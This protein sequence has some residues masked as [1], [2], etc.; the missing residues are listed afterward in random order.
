[1]RGGSRVRETL[2]RPRQCP[3]CGQE[4]AT[5]VMFRVGVFFFF[6][7]FFFFSGNHVKTQACG[8]CASQSCDFPVETP[9][10]LKTMPS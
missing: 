10:R 8:P 2:D 6:F 5:E 3:C 9:T 4:G 7:F 1:M